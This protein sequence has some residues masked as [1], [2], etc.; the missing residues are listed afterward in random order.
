MLEARLCSGTE[1]IHSKETTMKIKKAAA[2][3]TQSVLI[4]IPR[5]ELEVQLGL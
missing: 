5:K 4:G 1:F 3:T 2:V